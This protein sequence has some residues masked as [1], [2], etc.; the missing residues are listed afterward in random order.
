MRIPRRNSAQRQQQEARRLARIEAS[1]PPTAA[2]PAAT[3]SS[4]QV[5]AVDET[6][7]EV[8]EFGR[9]GVTTWDDWRW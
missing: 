7:G 3:T 8:Y 2:A 5:G 9:W 4:V 1:G 6:T